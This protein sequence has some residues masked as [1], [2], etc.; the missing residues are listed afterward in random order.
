M[1]LHNLIKESLFDQLKDIKTHDE[2]VYEK[3]VTFHCYWNKEIGINQLFSILSCYLTNVKDTN[4]KIILWGESDIESYLEK[5][6]YKLLSRFCEVKYFDHLTE[7][8]GTPLESYQ[9]DRN[10]YLSMPSFYSDYLR[11]IMLYKYDGMWFDLDIL[12]F[13]NFDY[14]FSKYDS[15]LSTWER[16]NYPNN[17]LFWC[18]DKNILKSIIERFLEYGGGHFGMQDTFGNRKE[19]QIHFSLDSTLEINTLPCGWF[20]PM[21]I[22]DTCDFDLW[23]KNNNNE[24]FYD[25]AYCYHWHNRNHLSIEKDSPFHRNIVKL[26]E[27][28]GLQDTIKI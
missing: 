17:A 7:R 3:P 23:F 5:P 21:W 25:D 1:I 16:S 14:L 22:C 8:V 9:I 27:E 2:I 28:L 24:Y 10:G 11:L 4:N 15:F 19:N 13:K 26:I 20:D 12:F 6:I 18:R